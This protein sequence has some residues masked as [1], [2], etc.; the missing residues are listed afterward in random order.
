MKKNSSD[1]EYM[2][3][4]FLKK[5]KKVIKKHKMLVGIIFLPII[6]VDFYSLVIQSP[7]YESYAVISIEQNKEGLGS[8]M[9]GSL[10]A[11]LTGVDSGAPSQVAIDYINSI[12][13]YTKLDQQ[14]GLSKMLKNR[15][16]DFISRMRLHPDQYSVL[17]YYNSL[18]STFYNSQSQTIELKFQG[19]SPRDSQLVLQQ[20]ISD[21]QGFVNDLDQQLITQKISFGKKQVLLAHKKL[22]EAEEKIIAFQNNK[23]MF[24]PKTEAGVIVG[25]LSSLQLQLVTAQTSL[26]DKSAYYQSDSIEIQS[27]QQRID[28]LKAQISIQKQRLMG[29]SGGSTDDLKLNQVLAQFEELSTEAKLAGAEYAASIQGLEMSRSEAIQQKQQVVIVQAPL[30]PDYAKYPRVG[31]NTLIMLLVLAMVYGV[32]KMF[33]RIIDEHNY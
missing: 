19:Y 13:M 9:A 20:I 25:I 32:M 22:I 24:D 15:K 21:V 14:I 1:I 12:D 28:T 18:V 27:I 11:G 29:I 2:I 10:L 17:R 5:L 7:R 33:I 4:N 6:L 30:L 8:M 16:I 23:D 3:R 26:A 31:Y